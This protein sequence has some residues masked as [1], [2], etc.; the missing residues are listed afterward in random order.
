[1]YFGSSISST[2]SDINIRLAKAWTASNRLSIIWKSDLSDK[3]KRNFFQVSTT[4]RMHPVD[5]DYTYR[6]KDRRKLKKNAKSHIK[7]I[8]GA[9]SHKTAAVQ[10]PTSHL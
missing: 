4:V 5:A 10:P 8:L 7:Q 6:E 3:I 2:E 1:M 9:T